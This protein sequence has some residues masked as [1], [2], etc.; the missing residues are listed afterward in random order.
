MALPKQSSRRSRGRCECCSISAMRQGR[1]RGASRFSS[2]PNRKTSRPPEELC[3]QDTPLL[4]GPWQYSSRRTLGLSDE[5][6]WILLELRGA[7]RLQRACGVPSSHRCGQ[8][9]RRRLVSCTSRRRTS[10]LA[11]DTCG[12]TTHALVG[13]GTIRNTD[14]IEAGDS[15]RAPARPQ[16]R[17]PALDDRPQ[18]ASAKAAPLVT[19]SALCVTRYWAASSGT[20]PDGHPA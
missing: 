5:I 11:R 10:A 1:L 19:L 18:I 6:Y 4:G 12:R 16:G 15:T 7:H 17:P 3:M 20:G 13:A 8:S 2:S 14:G 9:T